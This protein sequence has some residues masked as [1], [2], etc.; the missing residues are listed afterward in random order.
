MQT[1]EG[2]VGV[3]NGETIFTLTINPETGEYEF[4]LVGSLDHADPNDPND[5]ITIEFGVDAIDADGDVASTT[6]T[7]NIIDDAPEIQKP[8][9]STVDET[10]LGPT[11]ASGTVNVDFGADGP[12][13]TNAFMLTGGLKVCDNDG[14]QIRPNDLTPVP[15]NSLQTANGL[16]VSNNPSAANN[17]QLTSG[18]EPVELVQSKAGF[19]GVTPNGDVI[20]EIT[21]NPETGEYTFTLLGPS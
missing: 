7:I 14:P 13:E 16:A 18:G 6:V 9:E 2:Y 20:F 1:K 8:A 21:L 15:A 10:D 19:Q 3:A 11:A 5:I 12:A 4:E 17:N